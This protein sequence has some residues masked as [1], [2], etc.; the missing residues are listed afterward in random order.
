MTFVELYGEALHHELGSEDTTELFTTVRRKAAINRAQREF[1]RLTQCF[2]VE[3]ANP[4]VTATATYDLDG[5]SDQLF[6]NFMARPLRLRRTVIAGGA[7]SET[8]LTRHD[9]AW[10]DRNREGWRDVPAEGVPDVWAFDVNGG[11]NNLV[12]NPRPLVPASETWDV[13]VPML[14]NPPDL[15]N[16]TDVPFSYPAGNPQMALEPFHWGLVH[17]AAA[18]LER[19]RKDTQAVEGQLTMFGA[20]VSDW[21]ATRRP[22][23]GDS[24][25]L[26]ARDYLKRVRTPTSAIVQGD[27]RV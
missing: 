16:D 22:R 14:I 27:P 21:K 3:L 25:V 15:S 9:A 7:A 6:V 13:L 11:S 12:F 8:R 18:Q 23:G 19:L 20:Y 26:Q 1:A 2:V 4:L 24:R 17:Y 10:L 5:L